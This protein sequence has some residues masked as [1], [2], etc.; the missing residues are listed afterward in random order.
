M[1][2]R[3][4]PAHVL[5]P[6]AKRR[7]AS[8]AFIALLL[9]S[10]FWP[11]PVVSIN[12]LWIGHPLTVDELSFLGREALSWDVVFWCFAGLLTLA[13]LHS[14]DGYD[15][16][17]ASRQLRATRVDFH[18][19]DWLVLIGGAILVA[20]VWSTA[21]AAVL[22]WAERIQSDPIESLIR[23]VNRFGGG[24][25]PALIVGFFLFAGVCYRYQRWISYALAMALTGLGAGLLAQLVKVLV[26]RTRPELWLGPAHYV[27]GAATSFPSGHTVGAFALAGVLVFGSRSWPVRIVALLLATA[28]GL[29]RVLAFRHWLSDVTA[30]AIIGLLAASVVTAAVLRAADAGR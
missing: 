7:Y 3:A 8:A 13:I 19:R 27:R 22:A 9:L 10:V 11:S 2:T 24:M 4:E 25:N 14:A 6:D 26:S 17:E 15:F 21:D 23:I 20:A 5:S 29:A 16:R 18:R 1:S 12:R 30:S 28:V